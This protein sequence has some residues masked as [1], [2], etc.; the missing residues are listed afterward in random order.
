MEI[1]AASPSPQQKPTPNLLIKLQLGLIR[2]K[3]TF[4]A[5]GLDFR[6]VSLG[7]F[8][9]MLGVPRPP[10]SRWASPPDLAG[11]VSIGFAGVFFR[12][13]TLR[14][15]NNFRFQGLDFLFRSFLFV[16]RGVC[17]QG[18]LPAISRLRSRSVKDCEH[19]CFCFRT[20]VLTMLET[21]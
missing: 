11:N 14:N 5:E 1:Q 7:P 17:G 4:P 19:L 18:R 8:R 21:F 9:T 12:F 3:C 16:R 15:L 10:R 2:K 13:L 6:E 20:E